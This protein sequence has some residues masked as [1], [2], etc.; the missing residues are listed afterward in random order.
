MEDKQTNNRR[1]LLIY[2][3]L[4]SQTKNLV[5]ALMDGLREQQVEVLEERLEPDET[6]R[7][8]IGSITATVSIM[9]Q[10]FFRKRVKIK[11][12]SQHCFNHFDFIIL[13]G[14]TWSYNPSGAVLSLLDRD[15]AKLFNGKVVLPLIS[16]RGYWRMHWYGLKRLL[17]KNG[18]SLLNPII[19]SHPT[20]EPWRTIGVFLK[21]AGKTPEKNSFISRYYRKYGHNRKQIKE[22]HHFGTMIGDALNRDLD[23]NTL[24]F[25]TKIALP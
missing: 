8:P 24:D 3:S 17:K 1:I 22:A 16:C 18:A 4:S 11:P 15:G 23:L 12:V 9:L 19:F 2:F 6:L 10:T 13:A 7:F 5:H 25:K 14:P 20:S 21:L